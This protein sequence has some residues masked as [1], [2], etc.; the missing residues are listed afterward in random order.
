MQAEAFGWRLP[1]PPE[2]DWHKLVAAKEGEISRLSSIYETN[3]LK[4]GVEVFEERAEMLGP[5]EVRLIKSGR[6]VTAQHILVATG[7]RPSMHPGR[8]RHRA[9]HQLERN[10]RPEDFPRRLAV[11][12]G[13]YIAVEFASIFARLGAKV[14]LLF[15]ADNIL[16][17][18]DETMRESLR[19][20][21][22]LAGIDQR[23]GVLPTDIAKTTAAFAA[24][25]RP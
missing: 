5:H 15:R 14:T 16:R 20:A 6:V 1:K 9:R 7:G 4:A 17:G 12:G 23:F 19:D 11:I 21:L 25:L 2:F 18:F 3:L 10:L 22:A 8:P 24:P 13:G